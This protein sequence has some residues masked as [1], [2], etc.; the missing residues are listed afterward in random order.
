M[1]I[2]QT[3]KQAQDIKTSPEILAQLAKNKDN[4]TR[5]YIANNPNTPKKILDYLSNDK[6]LLVRGN[7]AGNFSTSD[8]V[9]R[10]IANSPT[11]NKFIIEIANVALD[12]RQAQ[13]K[14][15]SPEKLAQL[16]QSK[17]RITQKYVSA[18]PKTPEK[19]LDYFINDSDLFI[20]NNVAKNNGTSDSTLRKIAN[21]STEHLSTI[22]VARN[23]LKRRAIQKKE[24]QARDEDSSPENL[25]KLAE[26]EHYQIRQY[27]ASNP[28]TPLD[29]LEKLAREFPA[30]IMANSILELLLLENPSQLYFGKNCQ[31]SH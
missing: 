6:D 4:L 28:N 2:E 22:N 27:V 15:T 8:S 20:R 12:R 13:N 21:S 11:E 1:N 29:V 31:F 24:T 17:D 19:I 26:N 30:E 9:L 25:A 3:Q 18:N 10:K 16:A 5:R 23:V 14:N 7:V